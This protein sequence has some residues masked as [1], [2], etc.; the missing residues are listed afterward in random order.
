VAEFGVCGWGSLWIPLL[1]VLQAIK[2]TL[3]ISLTVPQKIENSS[4]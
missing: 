3:E 1:V 2:T 4:S